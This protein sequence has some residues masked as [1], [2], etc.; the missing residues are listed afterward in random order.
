MSASIETINGVWLSLSGL[1]REFGITRE[2]VARRL[3]AAGVESDKERN[4]HAVF[5]LGPASQALTQAAAI[6]G[7]KVEDPDQLPAAERKA[8]YQSEQARLQVELESGRLVTVED[9][10]AQLSIIVKATACMLETL[11]DIL[12]RDAGLGSAE[13]DLVEA[14]IRQARIAWADELST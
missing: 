6:R 11:P 1:S 7:G 14:Q 4:G 3:A 8:W 10:R 13:L 12:E 9:C 5:R 2:T